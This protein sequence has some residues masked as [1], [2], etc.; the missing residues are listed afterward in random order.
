[1]IIFFAFSLGVVI[2]Y[3]YII[4]SITDGWEKSII[5]DL[6]DGNLPPHK[7]SVIIAAR[8]EEKT[9]EKCIQSILN[10]EYDSNKVEIIV[11]DDNS[12]DQTA[13]I[14]KNRFP[15]VNLL[16]LRNQQ[17][18]KAAIEKGAIQARYDILA[19]TDADCEVNREWLKTISDIYQDKT[20]AFTTGPVISSYQKG[21][22]QAFQFLDAVGMAQVTANGISTKK[23]FIANGANMSI[24]KKY[25]D[26]L[27]GMKDHKKIA[28]GDDM[29]LIQAIGDLLPGKIKYAKKKE[30]IV[31]TTPENSWKKL[32][33]QRKRWAHKTKHYA[34][35]NIVKLQGYIFI[36]YLLIILN[37]ILIPWTA[38]MSVFTAIFMLFIKACIDYLFLSNTSKLFFG[39]PT[40]L[41]YFI[42][43]F[44][45]HILIYVYSAFV[46]LFPK[47]Y[48]WK[49]R[50]IKS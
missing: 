4:M 29:F 32:L 16:S 45:I 7:I 20:I 15:D 17:G 31:I 24:R 43:A 39:D 46:A 44:F 40:P 36:I 33:Q 35:R 1:M 9:I 21:I 8:N 28:S 10:N 22:L 37:L 3:V 6:E 30:A 25:F 49:G 5:P 41:K 48:V 19:F 38:G 13:T 42:P 50:E 23:Y 12:I 27:G 34:S 14:I 26:E 2:A 18:K 11:V 47:P